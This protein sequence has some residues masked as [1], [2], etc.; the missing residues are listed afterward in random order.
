MPR[1]WYLIYKDPSGGWSVFCD[2]ADQII[3]FTN[4]LGADRRGERLLAQG[5]CREYEVVEHAGKVLGTVVDEVQVKLPGSEMWGVTA[6]RYQVGIC[7]RCG[8][9]YLP[10]SK[11]ECDAL[12][13]EPR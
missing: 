2:E 4:L 5:F 12:Q 7:G 13:C 8:R 3:V 9:E 10:G 6:G 11:S 1:S